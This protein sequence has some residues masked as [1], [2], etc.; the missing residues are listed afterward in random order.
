M[1]TKLHYITSL[2]LILLIAGLSLANMETVKVSYLLGYFKLPLIILILVSVLLGAIIAN[3][4]GMGK[5]FAIKAELKQAQKELENQKRV[6]AE[7][8]KQDLESIN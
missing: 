3:L 2:L 8:A 6:S 4:I 5:Q 7:Q 1:K